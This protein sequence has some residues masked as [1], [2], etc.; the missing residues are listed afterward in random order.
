MQATSTPEVHTTASSDPYSHLQPLIDHANGPL[1]LDATCD[2]RPA[3]F[4][5]SPKAGPNQVVTVTYGK[6]V[7][8][9]EG[10][11]EEIKAGKYVLLTSE[12][13]EAKLSSGQETSIRFAHGDVSGTVETV[14]LES[15]AGKGEDQVTVDVISSAAVHAELGL[16]MANNKSLWEAWSDV[17]QHDGDKDIIL[18]SVFDGHGG[19]AVARLLAAVLHPMLAKLVINPL[20][21]DKNQGFIGQQEEISRAIQN[22]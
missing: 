17:K 12:E 21:G 9:P 15:K 7:Y 16:M 6:G 1:T 5:V 20:C 10:D 19:K 22:V 2:G 11:A 13:C 4:Q 8:S 14:C 18:C 3:I